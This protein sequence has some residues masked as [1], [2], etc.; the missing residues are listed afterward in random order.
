MT[1]SGTLITPFHDWLVEM[2]R[3]FH[4]YPEL[5]YRE[6]RTAARIVEIL[7]PLGVG[8]E[9]GIGATGIVAHLDA[10]RPGPTLALRADMDALPLP[11]ARDIPYR[12]KHPGVM[13]ACGHDGHLAI[14]LGT[15]RLLVESGW[16]EHGRGRI[17]FIFQPAEE[18]GAGARAMLASGCLDG[19]PIEAIFAGHL[20]PEL[21][22]GHIGVAEGVSNAASD[23]FRVEITGKG[24]HGAQPHLCRDPIVAGAHCVA[25]LQTVVSRSV[26]PLDAAVITVGRFQAGTAVNIIPERATLEGTV[27]TLR[28]EVRETTLQRMEELVQGLATAFQ[29][30]VGLTVAPGYPLLINHSQI[31][32]YIEHAGRS[33]L[34]EAAVHREQPRMGAEDFAYFLERYPGALIRLGCSPPEAPGMAGL[35]SPHFDFDENALDV[36]VMLFTRL[37]VGFAARGEG[38]TQASCGTPLP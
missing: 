27:R 11:E 33:L 16:Q 35:H 22:V 37:L 4:Q 1:A 36:G 10:S 25:Q 34:G 24:G 13:H 15:A 17:L 18:G 6:K 26:P 8:M 3:D 19:E 14:A 23:T 20:H 31:V 5:A 29:L 21:A 9:T 2:R 7:R 38:G 28:P 32:S 30:E 12:S